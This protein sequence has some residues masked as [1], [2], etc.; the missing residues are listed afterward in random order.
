[1]TN[2]TRESL[3]ATT[4][5]FL[6]ANP[7]EV[8]REAQISLMSQHSL[9]ASEAQNHADLLYQC[10]GTSPESSLGFGPFFGL[11]E[12]EPQWEV[13][14]SAGSESAK[15]LCG[16]D[17]DGEIYLMADVPSQERGK[18]EKSLATPA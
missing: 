15:F 1:M 11:S 9:P 10:M 5:T 7:E 17:D 14:L 13:T 12:D 3:T 6:A 4:K 8:K 16:L 2:H 18:I